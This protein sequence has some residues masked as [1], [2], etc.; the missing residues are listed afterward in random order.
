M[1]PTPA[2]RYQTA[3]GLV[4]L[5]QGITRRLHSVL[6]RSKALVEI[7]Q[8]IAWRHTW[9]G[10]PDDVSDPARDIPALEDPRLLV[11]GALVGEEWLSDAQNMRFNEE[12]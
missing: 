9:M 2:P 5:N 8:I 12:L 6:H 1:S 10:T 7:E 11:A 3:N 4:L